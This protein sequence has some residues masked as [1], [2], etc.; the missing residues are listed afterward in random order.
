MTSPLGAGTVRDVSL[1]LVTR[2]AMS[3]CSDPALVAE[4][5]GTRPGSKE[6]A[7]AVGRILFATAVQLTE[8]SPMV[9]WVS[10]RPVREG[11]HEEGSPGSLLEELDLLCKLHGVKVG[12]RDPF[13][14]L[15]E[16]RSASV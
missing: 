14:V 11:W 8:G 16:L 7:V 3:V 2:H 13:Q 1:E 12:D 6:A 9:H 4:L 15:F 10:T 5:R